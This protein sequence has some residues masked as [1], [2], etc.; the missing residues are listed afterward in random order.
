MLQPWL[1]LTILDHPLVAAA[2]NT[3]RNTATQTPDFRRACEV[4]TM[5]LAVEVSRD[6]ATKAGEVTTPLET[7]PTRVPAEGIAVVAILRAGVGMVEPFTRL[8]PDVAVGYVG[9]ERD[10]STAIAKTYYQKLPNLENRVVYVVDPM[11][12]TGGSAEFTLHAL[13]RHGARK[14]KFACIVAA[15]EGVARLQGA[16]P[17]LEI[18][19]A[20]LD[21]EL[22]A[23]KY[24]LP[25]M[26][27]F[28]DRLFGT[29]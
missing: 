5:H 22:N 20:A 21:R 2:L 18:M 10:E 23:R 24:I 7:M 11:L 19:T 9:M 17:D 14:V 29:V 12:A 1:M 15:P 4:V 28:G 6:L 25:G 26:G 8:L 13:K 27:D 3:L 16:F